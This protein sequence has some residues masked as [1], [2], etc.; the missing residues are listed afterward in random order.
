M[1][2]TAK[3]LTTKTLND[4]PNARHLVAF[5]HGYGADGQDLLGLG[6]VMGDALPNTIFAAPDAPYPCLINSSGRAWFSIPAF[7]GS[8]AITS[9]G[10]LQGSLSALNKWLD[11]VGESTGIP[12]ERTVLFGF[13]QGTMMA[14]HVAPRRESSPAAVVGFSGR[15]LFSEA[16]A[17]TPS[18]PPIFLAHGDNDEVV[19][20]AELARA[21]TALKGAGFAVKTH[22]TKNAGHTIAPDA[23]ALAI[24]FI[25]ES[26]GLETA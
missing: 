16:L 17:S 20:Y 9:G 12:A 14:L 24:G 15:L 13:S 6:E 4:N 11:E 25:R 7:D 2:L 10:Q 3:S 26:L 23:L 19:D 1:T 18:R 8:D 22:T 21:E 5:L